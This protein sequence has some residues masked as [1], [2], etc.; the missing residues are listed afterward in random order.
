MT[1]RGSRRT[2]CMARSYAGAVVAFFMAASAQGGLNNG[3]FE[4]MTVPVGSYTTISAG[5]SNLTGWTVVGVNVDLCNTAAINGLIALI[6][7]D[8]QQ[9][10][11]LTGF[12]SNSPGN[13]VTQ[14]VPTVVGQYYRVSF[15]VGSATDNQNVFASTVDVSIDGGARQSF[16]NP[17]APLDHLDWQAFSVDFVA[18]STTTNIGFFNG[19]PNYSHTCAIDNVSFE[20]VPGPGPAGVMGLFG[21]LVTHRRRGDVRR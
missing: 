20:Q 2:S 8:G 18:T 9:W 14:D 17:N 6:A 19:S 16:T 10:L 5:S 15:H 11:D 12:G 4:Q 21:I 3:S 1:T 13:G 7:N